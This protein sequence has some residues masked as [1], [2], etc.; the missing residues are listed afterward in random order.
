M[1]P[2]C[3][4]K[5]GA[6]CRCAKRE[7]RL[8]LRPGKSG[9]PRSSCSSD[10]R[11]CHA[12]TSRVPFFSL[13]VPVLSLPLLGPSPAAR[14]HLDGQASGPAT[15]GARSGRAMTARAGGELDHRQPRCKRAR[16]TGRVALWHGRLA[17]GNFRH[18]L[19]A[20]ATRSR[21]DGRRPVRDRGGPPGR[22]ALWPGHL[23]GGNLG[24]RL[25]ARAAWSRIDRRRRVRGP[26]P[27]KN[28]N[29][30]R[31]HL[32]DAQ[33]DG[34]GCHIVQRR[35][36]QLPHPAPRAPHARVVCSLNH[37][38]RPWTNLGVRLARGCCPLTIDH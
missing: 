29:A 18:G 4:R 20:R 6:S 8:V 22:V 21:T 27:G 11:F 9:V 7:T 28:G 24:H 30:E 2:A 38:G 26:F 19:K 14:T 5:G 31:F 3:S 16:L 13:S 32:P 1:P 36:E 25:G 15:S 23:A 10:G 37:E 12:K 34:V 17:R 35:I 33:D